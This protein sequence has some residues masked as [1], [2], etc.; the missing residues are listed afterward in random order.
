MKKQPSGERARFEILLEE[1]RSQLKQVAEGHTL[2]D[3]KIDQEVGR[4]QQ[5]ITL[6]EKALLTGFEDVHREFA[7]VHREFGDVH[8]EFADV[9]HDIQGLRE[10]VIQIGQ[11]METHEKAHSS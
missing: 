7:D 8:R 10:Q 9:H 3:H 4:L 6:L 1:V 11:R 2:L 5:G